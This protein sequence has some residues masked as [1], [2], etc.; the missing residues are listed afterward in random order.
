[1]AFEHITTVTKYPD[2]GIEYDNKIYVTSIDQAKQVLRDYYGDSWDYIA[3]TN[4]LEQYR[5][6]GT[7]D[8]LRVRVG[9]TTFCFEYNLLFFCFTFDPTYGQYDNIYQSKGRLSYEKYP[10][11]DQVHMILDLEPKPKPSNKFV[12]EIKFGWRDLRWNLFSINYRL[13][14]FIPT[15]KKYTT[16]NE[17]KSDIDKYISNRWPTLFKKSQDWIIAPCY[18]TETKWQRDFGELRFKVYEPKECENCQPI[19]KRWRIYT[20]FHRVDNRSKNYSTD[21][22][23]P[24]KKNIK[25]LLKQFDA[26][27]EQYLRIYTE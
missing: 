13:R 14:R 6:H 15:G 20:K 16:A 26:V 19:E 10:T 5:T 8:R 12:T 24:T 1:M 18:E 2:D 27:T 3:R 21:F 7:E 22:S 11:I 25:K 4:N 17:L 23:I 9:K